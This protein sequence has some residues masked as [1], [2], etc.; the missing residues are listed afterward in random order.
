[1]SGLITQLLA[2]ANPN[3]DFT[4]FMNGGTQNI[5]LTATSFTGAGVSSFAG[6]FATPGATATGNGSFSQAAVPEPASLVL[7]AIGMSGLVAFGR[8]F[9]KRAT[10]A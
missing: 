1:M 5:T 7:L 6:L 10:V 3:F 2:N 4:P 8:T 9:R